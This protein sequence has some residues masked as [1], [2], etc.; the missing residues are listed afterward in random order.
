M[1][2]DS[3]KSNKRLKFTRFF[4]KNRSCKILK[5]ALPAGGNSFLDTISLSI[6]LLMIATLGSAAIVAVGVSLSFIMMVFAFC[7]VLYAGNSALVARF[8]GAGDMHSVKSIVFSNFILALLLCVPLLV[9]AF[10]TWEAFFNW[11]GVESEVMRLGKEYMNIALFSIAIILL[12]Q[13]AI[14]AFSAAGETLIP[15]II[16]IFTIAINIALKYAL[17]F[18][19]FGFA[20]LELQGAAIS[21][22]ITNILEM[23]A[24]YFC[25]VFY[26][27][28][29]VGI[30]GK[31]SLN[32]IA[33]TI[34]I[35]LPT[36]AERALTFLASYILMKFVASYGTAALAGFQIAGRIEGF[37]YMPGFGF[38][39]ASM[40]L[41]GQNLGAKRPLE[42]KYSTMNTLGLGIFFMGIIGAGMSIFAESL[43]AIFSD[44]REAI[45]YSAA[46][47][48]PIGISQ[49]PFAAILILDGALR[50]AGITKAGLII[51]TISIWIIRTLPCYILLKI[52][53]PLW[54]LYAV[55]AG[56]TGV[57]AIIFW[58]YFSR[59][60]WRRSKV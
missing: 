48:V 32:F 40:A 5:I 31:V 8:V 33:R 57:R 23:L 38:M 18:G 11:V 10:S 58:W 36:G 27:R 41:M 4:S 29:K 39:V 28:G 55:L 20:R 21:T 50:G 17:I 7:A 9:L 54:G 3:I 16:K 30:G 60:S 49:V 1:A 56:E 47:L 43:S 34:R 2:Q 15:L 6:D 37:A 59:N 25:L 46:Y 35:G 52:G 42:A 19:E 51:N 44:E 26:N 12:R 22:L 24:L 13:V 14:S 45:F 53:A